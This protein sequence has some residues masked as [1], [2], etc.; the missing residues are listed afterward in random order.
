MSAASVDAGRP[1]I[2]APAVAMML[3]LTFSWGL[4]TVAIKLSNAGYNP[5]LGVFVR[6]ALGGLLVFLWCRW[7][8]IALFRRDGTFWPGLVAGVLFGLEFILIFAGLEYTSAARGTLM[9]NAMPFWMLLCGHF[10]LGEKIT[11]RKLAGLV[12]AFAGVMVIFSDDLSVAGPHAIWG[13]LLC[14]LAGIL[15]AGTIFVIKGTRLSQA[16]AEKT[17]LYQLFASAAIAL[18]AIPLFGPLLRDVTALATAS[19]AFQTVFIVA[20]TYVLWF[21]LVRRYPAPG[22]SSFAFLTPAFGV[23]LAGLLLDE[24]LTGR[25]FAA[26]T[27][28]AAGLVLVNRPRRDVVAPG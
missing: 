17:L 28:I 7:S 9:V 24:P 11:A 14:L 20:F 26:L 22:L 2:D 21:W 23:I 10:L 3:M 8:G 6:S 4:N 25:I 15:W 12:L 18:P 5:M 19:L 1:S 27:L 16:S 13:D